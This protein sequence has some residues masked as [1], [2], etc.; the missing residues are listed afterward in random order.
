MIPDYSPVLQAFLGTLFTW[1]LTAA[2]AALVICIRGSQVHIL[3]SKCFIWVYKILTVLQ[4][5]L[6]DTSLGFAA[7][8]MTAASYWSLLSPA[9]EMAEESEMYG[10]NGQYAFIPVSI[11]F[12]LGALFVFGADA[13]ISKTGIHST[14]MMLGKFHRLT[15]L[16]LYNK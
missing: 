15:D 16:L 7:G 3:T 5:K 11:G 13:L 4:R 2:G 10:S 6:L 14:N 12:L 9:I 8:V 1:G